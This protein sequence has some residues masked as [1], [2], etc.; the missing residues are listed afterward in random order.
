MGTI[1]ICF[2]SNPRTLDVD[3]TGKNEKR[4]ADG[5]IGN[6][7]GTEDKVCTTCRFK[8]SIFEKKNHIWEFKYDIIGYKDRTK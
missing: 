5:K 2:F 7:T 6:K 1:N 3:A 4:L 8:K